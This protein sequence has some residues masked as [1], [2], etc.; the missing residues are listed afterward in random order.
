VSVNP[1]GR[2]DQLGRPPIDR[3]TY[4]VLQ[5]LQFLGHLMLKGTDSAVPSVIPTRSAT[6]ACL[7]S[8]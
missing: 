3:L 1:I 6:R 7:V 2:G 8:S 5:A 4:A